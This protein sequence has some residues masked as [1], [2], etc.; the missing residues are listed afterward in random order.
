LH[1]CKVM[2]D[3]GGGRCVDIPFFFYCVPPFVDLH[4]AANEFGA[5]MR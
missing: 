3:G 2:S 4:K 5:E 1:M